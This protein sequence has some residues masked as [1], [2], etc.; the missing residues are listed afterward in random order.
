MNFDMTLRVKRMKY[1]AED[2]A[3]AFN[4]QSLDWNFDS[5]EIRRCAAGEKHFDRLRH[6]AAAEFRLRLAAEH[7]DFVDV[8]MKDVA[9]AFEIESAQR[10]GEMLSERVGKRVRMAETFALDDF[11]GLC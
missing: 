4:G 8:V 5:L 11:K 7:K 9:E 3:A 6:F 2:L 10:D 1:S